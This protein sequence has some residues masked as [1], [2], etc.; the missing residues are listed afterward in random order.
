MSLT[1]RRVLGALM[2]AGGWPALPAAARVPAAEILDIPTPSGR[3]CRTWRYAPP[4]RPRGTI[5][6][7]HGAASAPWKYELLLHRWVDAGYEVLAPLHVDSTDHPGR[8]S[9]P[10]LTGWAARIEDMRAVAATI[11]ARRYCAAGH[12]YG[13]LAALALGGAR[14][15]L[16]AGVDGPIADPRVAAVLAFS[17]PGAMAPLID[18]T[19]YAGLAVPALIQTGTADIPPGETG[20]DGH[21][22][23]WEAPTAHGNRYALV[24]EG[25]DHY[26]GGAICR[27]ELPGP[28]QERELA[29]AAEHT[30]L[31]LDAWLRGSARARR[32][33]DS[34]LSPSGPARFMRR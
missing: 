28:R 4:R 26:F 20:W 11:R 6:F 17:P 13:A 29:L 22:L 1:R 30:R 3:I 23:S 12:S 7:L 27:P 5:L 9:F 34:A 8:A 24:L 10:G 32:M 19:G 18:R 33:L 25:V 14:P 16:P 21:L 15:L 2:A 31:M